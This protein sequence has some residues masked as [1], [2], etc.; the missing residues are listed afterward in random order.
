[1]MD[2]APDHIPNSDYRHY[3]VGGLRIIFENYGGNNTYYLIFRPARLDTTSF[4]HF[5]TQLLKYLKPKI[6]WKLKPTQID[7]PDSNQI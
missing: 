2:M 1:M 5:F 7:E 3:C 4:G 6:F